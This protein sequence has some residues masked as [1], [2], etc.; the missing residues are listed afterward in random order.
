MLKRVVRHPLW[1]WLALVVAC[2]PGVQNSSVGGPAGLV[3]DHNSQTL[4]EPVNISVTN[5][6]TLE[7]IAVWRANDGGRF[8]AQL[9]PGTYAL[10]LT[11]RAGYHYLKKVS[12][13]LAD[14]T[15]RLSAEC[16]LVKGRVVGDLVLP[17]DIYLSRIS[18][19]IGDIFVAAV[20][21]EG[22][23]AACLPAGRY[24][25]DVH[26]ET[27]SVTSSVTVPVDR[28]LELTG[29]SRKAVETAPQR[30]ALGATDLQTFARALHGPRMLGL[31][32]ANHGTGSFYEYRAALSFELARSGRL[33]YVLLEADAVSLFA[34]DDYV[35]GVNIDIAKAVAAI[36]FWITDTEEFLRFLGQV[37]EFNLKRPASAQI[38]VL[39]VD[40]QRLEPPIRLLLDTLAGDQILEK[41]RQLLTRLASRRV[42]GSELLSASDLSALSAFLGRLDVRPASNATTAQMRASVAARSIKHQLGSIGAADPDTMRDLAMVDLAT[43]I[44]DLYGPGQAALWAHNAHV[45]RQ[46]DG[47]SRTLGQF[48]SERLGD[49]Y[50]PIGFFSYNGSARAWDP[51]GEIGVIVHDLGETSKF[52]V[53]TV[54]MEATGF[55]DAAWVRLDA[56]DRDVSRWFAR[57]RYVREFGSAY[58]TARSQTLR[59]FPEALSAIVVI[60]NGT[61]SN[62]TPTGVRKILR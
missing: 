47:A 22:A 19:D 29:Y 5:T 61:A 10:A 44:V 27:V 9:P 39:G 49:A 6:A 21:T 18:N 54:I 37:R 38:H 3:L 24:V 51:P 43:H 58:S 45:A 13:P 59:P 62:P 48:M 56:V 8:T 26:G 16:H 17:A 41:E 52:N 14:L 33:R 20:D 36:G 7:K 60:K 50:Y 4:A 32:E 42:V 23:F 28:P 55:P 46:L 35:Q 40:A 31:G 1:I 25:T 2:H 15:V 53:E 12:F 30:L 34:I 57:P 11:S